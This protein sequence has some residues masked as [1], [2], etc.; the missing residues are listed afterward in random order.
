MLSTETKRILIVDDDE[1][2]CESLGL[3]LESRGYE[4]DVAKTGNE[5]I[6]KSEAKI[7]NLAIL[8][9][10]LP[11]IEGTTL[12]KT[13]R[14]TTPKMVKIMLTGYPQ[15]Q[16]AIDAVNDRA[17]AYFKKPVDIIQLLKT[18]EDRLE[19]QEEAKQV[20]EEKLT[21]YLKNRTEKL[22]QEPE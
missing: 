14:Q 18:I 10:K 22:L 1:N 13:M 17:D 9:I 20:T 7:Y 11:D 15:L 16:N 4:V 2:I 21:L 8:D 12:L 3:I 5:A 19:E 6:K